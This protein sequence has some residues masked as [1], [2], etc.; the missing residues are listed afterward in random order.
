MASDRTKTI[1]EIDD[2][3]EMVQAMDALGIP[4]K[5]L[6]TLDDMK[7]R[8]RTELKQSLDKPSWTAGQVRL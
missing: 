6:K 1:D 2:I 7:D 4:F 3:S 5:G 8:V